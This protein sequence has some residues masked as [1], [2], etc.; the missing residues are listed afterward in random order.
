MALDSTHK[1]FLFAGVQVLRMLLTEKD[2]AIRRLED[3]LQEKDQHFAQMLQEKDQHFA[4]MLQEKDQLIAAKDAT[5]AARDAT[6]AAKDA[7]I[8]ARNAKQEDSA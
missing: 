2:A 5:I 1:F 7:T 6:I 4:Q 3:R 8:A